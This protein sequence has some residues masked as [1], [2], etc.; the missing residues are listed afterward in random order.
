[1]VRATSARKVCGKRG[2]SAHLPSRLTSSCHTRTAGSSC[3]L[4]TDATTR[5]IPILVLSI[6]DNKALGYQLGAFDYLLK[7][8]DG[9]H[10]GCTDAYSP[11]ARLLVVDDDPQVVDLVR[12]L[13]E[14]EPYEVIAAADGQE[15]LE[16]ISHQQPDIVLLICSCHAWTA[17]RSLSI[18]GRMQYR[19]LPSHCAH[20]QNAHDR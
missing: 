11:R 8:F 3:T 9:G 15:A 2:P 20:G 7:P 4:K 13:L 5:D 14:G 19:Q 16:A 10:P 18:S 6:V 17:L 12:Q 1:M